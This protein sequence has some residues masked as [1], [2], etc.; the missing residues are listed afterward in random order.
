MDNLR[1]ILLMTAA[2]GLFALE[3][4]MIKI[5]SARLPIGEI[6]AI[7]GAA[8]FALFAAVALYRRERL[9]S[10]N[11][12]NRHVLIRNLGEVLGTGC[13]VY[14][15]VFGELSTA[16]AIFQAT[17]LAV[18]LGAALFLGAKVGW[19]RWLAIGV[20]F[21]GVMMIVRPGMNGFDPVSSLAIGTVIFLSARDLAT[22]AA[23][24]SVTS[25]QMSAYGFGAVT[26][27]GLLMM[28]FMQPPVPLSTADFWPL[29][30]ATVTGVGGYY[31]LTLSMRVGDI[32]VITPFRYSRLVFALI[33]S[34]TVFGESPDAWTLSGAA[35]II[36]SGLYTLWREQQAFA[37]R[38]TQLG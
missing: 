33:F 25:L 4:M 34:I 16:T 12:F 15:F 21:C 10:R 20:G 23:P 3:D 32:P 31:A 29:A 19:R 37:R 38:T 5:A 35:V 36:A 7:L 30:I 24:V 17:P 6:L 8:G 26:V 1:G 14:A 22:R 18:T 9:W 28:F 2:M 27:L 13:F 11:L